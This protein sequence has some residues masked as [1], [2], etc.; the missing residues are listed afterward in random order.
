MA[1]VPAGTGN[2][3]AATLGMRGIRTGIDAIR[4]GRPTRHRPR[5]G[6]LDTRAATGDTT[7]ERIFAVACGMGLDARIMAAAEHEW[8]RRM[9]FGA[10][11]GAAVR[12][13]LRLDRPLPHRGRRRGPRH[14]GLSGAGR[15]RR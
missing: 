8:K 5:P 6:A 3:L 10:Y 9:G 13:V 7:E 14:R 11:V 4:H 1:I 15:Q 2:V 12:E